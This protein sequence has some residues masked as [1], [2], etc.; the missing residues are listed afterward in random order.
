M[1]KLR[2]LELENA[3][4]RIW[5]EK[6]STTHE[7][8]KAELAKDPGEACV[9][10]KKQTKD[11]ELLRTSDGKLKKGLGSLRDAPQANEEK[12]QGIKLRV[13][14][15]A[16]AISHLATPMKNYRSNCLR[17]TAEKSEL[18]KRLNYLKRKTLELIAPAEQIKA[19]VGSMTEER[20]AFAAKFKKLTVEVL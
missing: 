4:P 14:L 7:K 12:A 15:D 16:I 18:Q 17:V 8:T 11:C 1:S 10:L 3:T 20:N 6:F 2:N 9:H 19:K 13:T 5:F